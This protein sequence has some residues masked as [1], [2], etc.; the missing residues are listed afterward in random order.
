MKR[1]LDLGEPSADSAAPTTS[2][3]GAR[4]SNPLTGRPYSTR[5]QSILQVRKKLPVWGFLDKLESLMKTNRVIVVE[6]SVRSSTQWLRYH[7]AA[8]GS[9]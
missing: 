2:R 3:D 8:A 5:Y 4:A 9:R 1:R 7:S 6:A